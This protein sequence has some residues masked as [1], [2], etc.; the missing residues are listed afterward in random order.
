MIFAGMDI[1]SRTIKT[2]LFDAKSQTMIACKLRDQGMDQQ[3]ISRNLY[4]QTLNETGFD[5]RDVAC[6]VA[7]G[8]GRNLI[9]FADS[10]VTEITCHA[11]G[12][13][14]LHPDARTII[15]IGGEDS[16]VIRLDDRGKVQ[17]FEM[18]DRCA[19]G[20]GRFLEIVAQRLEGDL[21]SVALAAEQCARP[22]AISSMCVVFAETEIIGLLASGTAMQDIMA[23]VQRSIASRIIGMI[24]RQARPPFYFT[25]GVS[26]VP[27]MAE[28]L[29]NSLGHEIAVSSNAQFTG[30]LGAAIMASRQ[31]A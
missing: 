10:T 14:H 19:A 13:L 25:G 17:D 6:T 5:G 31:A 30:A 12:V 1:G 27:G 3:S 20:T 23:G 16:K 4:E 18:N 21:H 11:A 29:P 15:D 2:A 24:G 9:D 8:Y 22:A 28:I 26:L 7:T